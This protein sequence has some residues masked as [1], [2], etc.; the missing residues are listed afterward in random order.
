[1]DF[2]GVMFRLWTHEVDV[3]TSYLW[4]GQRVCDALLKIAF[5]HR[6]IFEFP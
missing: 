1:M 2:F 3:Q 6:E 4:Q 5:L